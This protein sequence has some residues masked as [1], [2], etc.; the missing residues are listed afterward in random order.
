MKSH[1]LKHCSL[2]NELCGFYANRPDEHE[3]PR[4]ELFQMQI[5]FHLAHPKFIKNLDR[6]IEFKKI[7]WI[8][9]IVTLI[10]SVDCSHKKPF[11]KF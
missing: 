10:F 9:K 4:L 1:K 11:I 6:D 2:I 8:E 5:S 3:S 7:L